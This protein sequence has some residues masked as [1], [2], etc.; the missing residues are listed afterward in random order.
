MPFTNTTADKRHVGETPALFLHTPPYAPLPT[1]EGMLPC[2]EGWVCRGRYAG[3]RY[4]LRRWRC[5]RR[6]D[7]GHGSPCVSAEKFCKQNRP[8]FGGVPFF[9]CCATEKKKN[10]KNP[11]CGGGGVSGAGGPE[12]KNKKILGEKCVVGV[13]FTVCHIYLYIKKSGRLWPLFLCF[14]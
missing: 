10:K 12:K 2:R 4:P 9:G 1:R 3:G 11:R 14:C 8:F 7:G 13:V 6:F 5:F